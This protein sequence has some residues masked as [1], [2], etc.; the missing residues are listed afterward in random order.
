MSGNA[1][2]NPGKWVLCIGLLVVMA[3]FIMMGVST[4]AGESATVGAVITLLTTTGLVVFIS[5]VVAAY[6]SGKRRR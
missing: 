5:S 4:P 3:E 6:Y 2:E 1:P